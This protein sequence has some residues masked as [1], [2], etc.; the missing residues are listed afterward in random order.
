[1]QYQYLRIDLFIFVK[2]RLATEIGYDEILDKVFKAREAHNREI[3]PWM[4]LTKREIIDL[5][6]D[7]WEHYKK[8]GCLCSAH[9][10]CECICGSWRKKDIK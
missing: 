2:E 10:D 1:M 7:N 8:G 6:D 5:D 9:G 4:E 3:E